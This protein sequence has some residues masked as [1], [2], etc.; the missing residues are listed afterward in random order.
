MTRVNN[1]RAL[2]R[3]GASKKK[4]SKKVRGSMTF[5]RAKALKKARLAEDKQEL[6]EQFEKVEGEKKDVEEQLEDVRGALERAER[7]YRELVVKTRQDR[8]K[9]LRAN[10]QRWDQKE[11]ELKEKYEQE[12][13]ETREALERETERRLEAE[14]VG[15]NLEVELMRLRS[16]QQ[17]NQ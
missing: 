15:I 12:L 11:R 10:K 16:G 5:W 3:A 1:H 13:S 6:K 8:N 2:V 9:V 7:K 17:G 14:E 4:P